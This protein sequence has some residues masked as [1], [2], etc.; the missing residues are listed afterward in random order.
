[1][2]ATVS[3]YLYDGVIRS[4]VVNKVITADRS[5]VSHG[6]LETSQSVE[7]RCCYL[8]HLH[9]TLSLHYKLEFLDYRAA[10]FA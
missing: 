3:L 8:L 9:L 5:P 4:L 7:K 6:K 10:L 2:E 1:L